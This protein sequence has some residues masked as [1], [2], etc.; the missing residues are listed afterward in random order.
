MLTLSYV[1]N[2]IILI[3]LLSAFALRPTQMDGVFGAATDARSILV[4]VYATIALTSLYGLAQLAAGNRNIA[5]SV[6]I[7]LFSLQIVYKTMT[8]I[9]V[10]WHSPVVKTNLVIVF[11]H[12][13]TLVALLRSA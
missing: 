7:T 12:V 4:C 3:P 6:G 1:A 11:I 2:L 8:V 9:A 10:G 5:V 13:I